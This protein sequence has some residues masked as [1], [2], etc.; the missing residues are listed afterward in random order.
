MKET[1]QAELFNRELDALLL[2][3]KAPS[4][5]SDPGAL[6]LA[7]ELAASDFSGESLIKESLR[8]RLAGGEAGGL[9]KALRELFANNYARAAM[10]VAVVVV[11]LLPLVHRYPGRVPEVA[12]PAGTASRPV[13]APAARASAPVSRPAAA[14]KPSRP[15]PAKG[16]FTSIPMAKLEAE[17]IKDFPIAAPAAL[18]PEGEAG[19]KEASPEKGPGAVFE[20]GSATFLLERRVITPADI[21]ERRVI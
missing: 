10:A 13:K 8:A 16:L 14:R 4:F 18:S 1:E 2:E 9:I 17:P 21:F 20:T 5:S 11:S 6:S 7:A 19:E 3:G 12:A 15:A